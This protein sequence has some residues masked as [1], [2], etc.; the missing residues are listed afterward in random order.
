MNTLPKDILWMIVSDHLPLKDGLTCLGTSK[1]F[2]CKKPLNV[3]RATLVGK[4]LCRRQKQY[5]RICRSAQARYQCI[6]CNY[7]HSESFRNCKHCHLTNFEDTFCDE[8]N[9]PFPNFNLSGSPHRYLN[10][11]AKMEE[12]PFRGVAI[13]LFFPDPCEQQPECARLMK[14]HK[15]ACRVRYC[16]LCEES[17]SA[18]DMEFHRKSCSAYCRYFGK[19]PPTRR[20]IFDRSD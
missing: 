17:V 8:C 6:F 9:A 2:W 1:F 16:G 5:I 19:N 14:M 4:S 3:C 10:C 18:S 11:P 13:P 15:S 12:C 20:K 7:Q